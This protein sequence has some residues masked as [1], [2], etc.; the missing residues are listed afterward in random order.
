MRFKA[1]QKKVL[2]FI[3]IVSI[4]LFAFFNWQNNSI[5]ISEMVFK[6]D[7]IPE[8][9]NGYKILQ[10]SD[11]HNKEFGSK[12][13]KILA[14]IE[15]INPDIIVITGDLIDSNN[16]NIDIAMELINGAINIAPIYYVSGNHE[17]WSG[18]YDDLKSNLENSGVVVLDNQKIEVFNDSDSIDIIGLADTA[19]IESDWLEYG[20]NAETK[21]LLNTL[22]EG[23]TNFKIL[24]SHRPELFDI[25]SNSNLNLI[26]SGH[27]HGGQFRLPFIGG[28]IAPDQGFF[29]KLTEG[30]HTSN[31][32]SMIISRGLGNSII[33]VRILN[34]PELIV[35]TLSK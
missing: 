18:S 5:I 6:N 32:T 9:F 17:V 11:L 35:V 14:E 13:N 25:Y 30:I 7:T 28:L 3:V 33:P 31:D 20:G 34:R 4:I 16:T 22:T 10:I 23:S 8:S 21:N 27:A 26:F 1:K 29:P 19:F 12:Q 15:K 24:L 2:L